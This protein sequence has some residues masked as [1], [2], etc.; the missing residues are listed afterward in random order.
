MDLQPERAPHG[1]SE[2]RRF[3]VVV[4]LF[5]AVAILATADLVADFGEGT[6]VGHVAIEGVMVLAGAIGA[7]FG[8]RHMVALGVAERTAR[9]SAAELS[10]RLAEVRTAAERWRSEAKDL[11]QGLGAAIDRQLVGWGLTAAEREIAVLLL[12]GLS[13]K[14]VAEARGVAEATVRQQARSVYRKAG[15]EGRHDLAAFFLEGVLAP[16]DVE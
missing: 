8:L 11:L 16:R 7:W 12:K 13:H 4:A 1:G 6:T 14:Q 2:R 5:A 10:A 3:G 9:A 15:V